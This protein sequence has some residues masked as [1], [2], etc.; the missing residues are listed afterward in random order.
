MSRY[1]GAL[2]LCMLFFPGLPG[3]AMADEEAK[4]DMTAGLLYV[5][6]ASHEWVH[7]ASRIERLSIPH[8]TGRDT[9]FQLIKKYSL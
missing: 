8:L 7:G 2:F 5:Q 1:L 6:R 9:T 3:V 4:F